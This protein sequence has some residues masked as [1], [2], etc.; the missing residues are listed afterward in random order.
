[1][2]QLGRARVARMRTYVSR[3]AMAHPSRRGR[4]GGAPQAEVV[5]CGT[6]SNPHGEEPQSGVSN[7][8]AAERSGGGSEPGWGR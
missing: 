7:H 3:L 2:A 8:E 6:K 4:Q 1:M 5:M